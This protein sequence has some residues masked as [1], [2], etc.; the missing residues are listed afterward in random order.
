VV[1]SVPGRRRRARDSLKYSSR[2]ARSHALRHARRLR[3]DV[4]SS[5]PAP[6]PPPATA[7]HPVA[8][9]ALTTPLR[10]PPRAS[11]TSYLPPPPSTPRPADAPTQDAQ[12]LR[13]ARALAA[14]AWRRRTPRVELGGRRSTS[15][16]SRR[17]EAPRR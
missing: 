7:I 17:S 5:R 10:T 3:H 6:S 4:S 2:T 9:A 8:A 16:G 11:P 14:P 12:A 15:H 1:E 13:E